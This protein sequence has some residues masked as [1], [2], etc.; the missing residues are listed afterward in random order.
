MT[1]RMVA[2]F[3]WRDSSFARVCTCVNQ[4]S[5]VDVSSIA[6]KLHQQ[7]VC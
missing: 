3:K 6:V 5:D 2:G 7:H 1:D 4:L